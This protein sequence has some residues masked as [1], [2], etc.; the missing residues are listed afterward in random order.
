[1]DVLAEQLDQRL[2][3]WR[4]EIAEQVRRYIREIMESADLGTLD[5]LRSQ[6]LE[7][8]VLDMLDEPP[9]R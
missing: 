2:H 1:M 5:L 8:E 7:Q 6:E 4:P 9:S 3:E